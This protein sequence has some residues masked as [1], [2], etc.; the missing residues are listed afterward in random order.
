[1]GAVIVDA[2]K[3]LRLLH[4]NDELIAIREHN[5]V[6][7]SNLTALIDDLTQLLSELRL[8]KKDWLNLE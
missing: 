5:N 7:A 8:E 1:M 6:L 2:D 4:I 3:F